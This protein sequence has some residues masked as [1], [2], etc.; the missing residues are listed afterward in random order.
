MADSNVAR[1]GSAVDLAGKVA[2]VT[3]ASKGIG[4]AYALAL[5]QAGATVVATARVLGAAQEDL[6]EHTL[7]GLVASARQEQ[8]AGRMVAVAC[9]LEVED[10][11]VR[12][13]D[14]VVA[15][16]ETVDILVNN[17]GLYPHHDP[18]AVTVEEWDHILRVN[19]RAPYL[20]IRQV[21][22]HMIRQGRGSII[23]IT[24]RSAGFTDREHDRGAHDGL[25]VYGVSKAALNRLTTYFAEELRPSGVAVN[26]LSP[27]GV[28]TDTWR[29]V[30]PAD[31]E[32]ARLSGKGKQ[33]VPEVLGPALLYLARQTAA[34]MT[35]QILH[36]DAF[37][38]TWP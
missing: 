1:T 25:F 36:T 3:G 34:T 12:V 32:A 26:A 28:L 7:A 10:D 17:A 33:P 21:A 9:D 16:L 38:T 13:V 14:E 37:G 19:V 31:F 23:N 29:Q 20:T 4:R 5:V 8:V 35:G 18:L 11:I 2:I 27:G 24:S 30:A 15:N 6:P 22:P